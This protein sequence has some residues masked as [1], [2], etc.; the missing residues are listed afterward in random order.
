MNIK[1]SLRKIKPLM[2]LKDFILNK[3]YELDKL[4]FFIMSKTLVTTKVY[5]FFFNRKFD[6]EIFSVAKGRIKFLQ[7][8]L[9]MNTLVRN[10]HRLEKGLTM[11]NRKKEFGLNYI[12]DTVESFLFNYKINNN[13]NQVIW[14]YQV[15]TKYFEVVNSPK[16][17]KI[18]KKFKSIKLKKYSQKMLPYKR[19]ENQNVNISYDEFFQLSKVRRS[20]RWFSNKKVEIEKILKAI[21]VPSYLPLHATDNLTNFKLFQINKRLMKLD[22]YLWEH[23]VITRTYRFLLQLSVS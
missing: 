3:F 21:D 14:S 20:V 19:K 10:I 4:F 9:N 7:N 16:L 18:E 11:R 1:K 12:N 23:Q 6:R 22:Q 5:Y 13:D 17:N 15:L 8:E 2:V